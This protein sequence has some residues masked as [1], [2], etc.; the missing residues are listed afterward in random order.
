MKCYADEGIFDGENGHPRV[1]I[2]YRRPYRHFHDRLIL[3]HFLRPIQ[4]VHFFSSIAASSPTHMLIPISSLLCR[5]W[6]PPSLFPCTKTICPLALLHLRRPNLCF[7]SQQPRFCTICRYDL[8]LPL[9]FSLP[10]ACICTTTI[11]RIYLL[12]S[13]VWWNKCKEEKIIT[14]SRKSF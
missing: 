4:S 12:I 1:R 6:R 3:V 11:F 2:F 5:C 10:L 13:A 14:A 8:S 7:T 9:F